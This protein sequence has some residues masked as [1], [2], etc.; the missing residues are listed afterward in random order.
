MG[1]VELKPYDPQWPVE[2]VRLQRKLEAALGDLAVRIDHIGST[3]VPGLGAKDCIDI[4]VSVGSLEHREEINQ[5]FERSGF[6]MQ[7]YGSDHEPP[8]FTGDEAEWSK[9]VF[10]PPDDE[11]LCNVHVREVGR[12]NR[13]YALLFRD[14]LRATPHARDTWFEMKGRLAEQYPND[15]MTYG[16]V[17]DAATD[18][19]MLIAEQW[20]ADSGWQP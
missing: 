20:A 16:Y 2:F 4:Q 9:M 17:K 8:G 10:S 15:S 3:S 6:T 1:R 7:P 5:A 14:Y 12:A 11:R 19:L 13:R 18:V